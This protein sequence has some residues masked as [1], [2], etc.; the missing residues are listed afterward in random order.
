MPVVLKQSSGMRRSGGILMV[1]AVAA[2]GGSC[3]SQSGP[4]D[5]CSVPNACGGCETL[6][7]VP[8]EACGTCGTYLCD[9]IDSVV[10]NS[11]DANACGGCEALSA[12]PGDLCGDCG[13]YTCSSA[14]AVTCSDPG[15]NGCGGCDL[16]P[17]EPGDACGDCGVITCDGTDLVSC[18]D[19]GPNACGGCATLPTTPGDACGDCGVITCDGTD[20]VSCDD[21]GPNVC[22]GCGVLA[23]APGSPCG[24]CGVYVCDGT[25]AV[26]CDEPTSC[27]DYTLLIDPTSTGGA[28]CGIDNWFNFT[29]CTDWKVYDVIPGQWLR[30]HAW[31]DSCGGCVLYHVDFN[32]QEDQG[33]G[34]QTTE[35]HDPEP[36]ALGMQYHTAYLPTTSQIRIQSASGF[37]ARVYRT[38]ITNGG[39]EAGG[40]SPFSTTAGVMTPALS[41]N[42]TYVAGRGGTSL[43]A[44]GSTTTYTGSDALVWQVSTV[45][46]CP[47]V[48]GAGSRLHFDTYADNYQQYAH[49]HAVLHFTDSTS[50]TYD[51]YVDFNLGLAAGWEVHTVDID[52]NDVGK[53]IDSI[54]ISFHKDHTT[55]SRYHPTIFIDN[56][57]LR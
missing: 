34:W 42:A 6:N 24:T 38:G 31:G 50:R 28:G 49:S 56:I 27:C 2:V 46:D 16:L 33:S 43:G 4:G 1:L 52:A 30:I 35:T 53:T 41:S 47:F 55:F 39:F 21:P 8:G 20:L 25:E 12:T 57:T 15:Y 19:P 5:N 51:N 48:I 10:C 13:E 17:G 7:W 26:V 44:V 36:D 14:D 9:G 11:P 32:I 29:P 3:A 18:D 54:D 23:D 45:L 37:Y 22:G 40:L